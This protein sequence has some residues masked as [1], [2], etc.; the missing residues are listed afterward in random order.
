MFPCISMSLHMVNGCRARNQLSVRG[1]SLLA[2]ALCV[3]MKSTRLRW[4]HAI[5]TLHS[6]PDPSWTK[7]IVFG[8]KHVPILAFLHGT[9]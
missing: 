6:R 2:A 1:T 3:A 8:L 9:F 4:L 5:L 7:L